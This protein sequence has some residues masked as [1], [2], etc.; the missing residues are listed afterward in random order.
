MPFRVQVSMFAYPLSLLLAV[1]V[2]VLSLICPVA[3]FAVAALGVELG[4]RFERTAFAA[5]L[6]SHG[7]P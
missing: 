2:A 3:C 1:G 7:F 5:L 6:L 4:Q